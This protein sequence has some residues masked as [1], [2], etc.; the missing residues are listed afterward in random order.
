MCKRLPRECVWF[1]LSVLLA[2]AAVAAEP[3]ADPDMEAAGRDAWSTYGTP[4]VVEKTDQAHS[5]K[6]ALRVVTDNK[7]TMGGNYEGTAHSLGQLQ[8]GDTVRVSFWYR[9]T[10]AHGLVIG[11][12]RTQMTGR[13]EIGGSGWQ[14]VALE[15][16]VRQPGPHS[17][18]L[19]QGGTATEFFLDDF[20]VTVTPR[21]EIPL[22]AEI[23]EPTLTCGLPF[24]RQTGAMYLTYQPLPGEAHP[25]RQ[26]RIPWLSLQL[27]GKD[28]ISYEDVP[29]DRLKLLSSTPTAGKTDAASFLFRVLDE[30]IELR[31]TVLENATEGIT[32]LGVIFNRS[33]RTI[34]GL[35]MPDLYGLRPDGAPEN[36]TL[37]HPWVCGRIVKDPLKSE[38][39]DTGY[40]GRGVMGWMDLAGEQRGLYLGVHDGKGQGVRLQAVPAPNASMDL[41]TTFEVC[42]RPGQSWN[43]PSVVLAQHPGDWH[44]GADI[45]RAWAEKTL[46]KPDVPQWMHD[47]NG[48][49]LVGLQNDIPFRHLDDIYRTGAWMGLEYLHIQGQQMDWAWW[50]AEGNRHGHEVTFPYPSPRL[51]GAAELRDQIKQIHADGG[52]VMCYVLPDRYTPS[53]ATAEDFGTGKRSD[54]PREIKIPDQ[55][56]FLD[57]ALVK[58]PGGSAPEENPPWEIRGMCPGSPGWREWLRWWAVDYY[59]KHLGADGMYWDVTGRVGPERC[60][61][62]RHG[63]AGANTWG[64]GLAELMKTVVAD[65]RKINPDY[66]A[67]IE[68]CSD[69]LGQWV[70]YHLM[71]GATDHQRVFRYTFPG[72]LLVDGFANHYRPWTMPQKAHRVFLEGEKFDVYGYHQYVKRVIDL[73]RRLKPF[74]DWP[75]VYRDDVGLEISSPKVQ[76]RRFDRMDGGNKIVTI[77]MLNEEHVE[78]ARIRLTG[79]LTPRTIALFHL[80]GRIEWG[81]LARAANVAVI[82]VPAEDISAA[83]IVQE[84][85]PAL[86][87]VPF[88]EPMTAPGDN[89]LLLT[90][91]TPMRGNLPV[92]LKPH[93]PSGFAPQQQTRL[94]EDPCVQRIRFVDPQDLQSLEQWSKTTVDVAWKGGKQTAWTMLAP[95]L[96]NGNFERVEGGTL[97]YWNV[98][99]DATNPGEGKTCVRVDA[100][101]GGFNLLNVLTPLKPGCRY[102]LSGMIRRETA[103]AGCSATMIEYTDEKN[104]VRSGAIS[105]TKAGEWE[106]LTTEFTTHP[107][108]RS[109]AIYLYNFSKTSPAWFDDLKIEEIK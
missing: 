60:F 31:I 55:Q 48:W 98:E 50:D 75:A 11:M 39:V 28:G 33:Q 74:T 1:G 2:T 71:S 49:L 65:G 69:V 61:N 58:F 73:R 95:P 77:T 63:H 59:A 16:R 91:F 54:I 56:W 52:H 26:R 4:V 15:Y 8:Q 40:P 84:A 107:N 42:V 51:G 34:L 94:T 86:Q 99:P 92:T 53:H 30:P 45:Y 21:P 76:A 32:C 14:P 46:R 20:A 67:A 23:P 43:S 38:G 29:F 72:Y 62:P 104:F 68:G 35:T 108:P 57:N 106:R 36:W 7:A 80:D 79:A 109:T 87:V 13:W 10:A 12:G 66:S 5:G 93:W 81:P 47:S 64:A 6:Q 78:G 97:D 27:L 82:P 24:G 89:G 17:I 41:S 70:G 9:V 22:L 101:P 83:V 96:V 103:D 88:L 102:R 37:V 19:S 105:P 3:F 25:L 100:K 85:A 90:L 44:K 18:W